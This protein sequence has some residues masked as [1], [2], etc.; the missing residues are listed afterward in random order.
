MKTKDNQFLEVHAVH[1]E[2]SDGG[3]LKKEFHRVFSIPQ[4]CDVTRM[5]SVLSPEGVLS[6]EAPVQDSK[7]ST[8]IAISHEWMMQFCY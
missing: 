3:S 8:A 4:H 6:I 7:Q 2:K 5:K 1:E